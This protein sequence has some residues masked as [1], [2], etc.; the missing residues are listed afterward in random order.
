MSRIYF[1]KAMFSSLKI[2]FAHFQLITPGWNCR[3]T[4]IARQSLII[5]PH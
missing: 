2:Q 3:I 4:G 1:L 5:L